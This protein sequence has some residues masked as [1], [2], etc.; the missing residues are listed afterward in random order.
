M[1]NL[2]GTALCAAAVLLLVVM[3]IGMA[4]GLV[5]LACL[6][7][8]TLFALLCAAYEQ[9]RRLEQMEKKLDALAP[10]AEEADRPKE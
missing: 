4:M 3:A 1:F 9:N 5:I 7:V 8:G 6:A 2:I 10:K